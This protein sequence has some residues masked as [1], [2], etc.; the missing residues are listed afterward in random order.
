MSIVQV[1]V[2]QQQA[3]AP[4]TLQSTGAFVSQGG[5]VLS[6]GASALLTQ[7]SDLTALLRGAVS[8]TAQTWSGG[9]VTATVSGGHGLISG[10][11]VLLTLAGALPAG[12]N[13]VFLA[14]VT[15]TT[16]FT[17]PVAVTLTSPASPLGVFSPEDVGELTAMATSFYANGG[18]QSVYVLELGDV[19]TTDAVAVLSAYLVAN[20]NTAYRPGDSGYYYGFLV[21]RSW[22]GNAAFLTLLASYESTTAATYFWVTTNLANYQNYT[23]LM[24]DVIAWIE[25]PAYGVWPANVLT[26][27]VY[28]GN[29]VTFTTTTAHGV[30]VGQWFR[31][32]GCTP[33][34]YN[35]FYLA[36]VGTTAS[37]LVAAQPVALGTISVEGSLQASLFAST[38][39]P[40]TEF[41]AAAGFQAALSYAPSP[42]NK[43]TP[44]EY[45]ELSGVT[46]FPTKGNSALLSTLKTANINVV[47]TGAEGGI[48]NAIIQGGRTA[49]G[50]DLTY[51]YSV[52]WANINSHIDLANEIINGSNNPANPLYYD[53]NG[54]NRLQ[55]RIVGRMNSAIAVGLA[56]TSVKRTSLNASDFVQALDAGIYDGFIVVNAIPFLDYVAV[57]PSD[58]RIGHYAGLTAEYIPNRGFDTITFNLQVTDLITP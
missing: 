44:Y 54:I 18:A 14:T 47:I 11:Q 34:G 9:V 46:P 42:S 51:W 15:S 32:L 41:T 25:A 7:L 17:Y 45:T 5:T 53:Q 23:T 28:S 19:D 21:P 8:L 16:Q 57:N 27:S 39:V 37:T 2:T 52:D 38:G 58:F 56:A 22:D 43:V 1:N 36:L 50:R 49:D 26:S 29:Q 48:T 10:E 24:K 3:P 35:G 33:A 4:A 20:P 55:D 13:G 12:Y 6:A 30:A 31:I 40:S